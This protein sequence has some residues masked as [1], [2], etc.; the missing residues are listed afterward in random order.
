[1]EPDQA[2][3]RTSFST[4]ELPG[5]DTRD[6][7]EATRSTDGRFHLL[8]SE[9]ARIGWPRAFCSDLYLHDREKLELNPDEP[10]VWVLR[11]NGTHLYRI[12]CDTTG[13]M[14]YC[15]AVLQ[16]WSGEDKLNLIPNPVER[17]RFYLLIEESLR[18]VDWKTA[19]DALQATPT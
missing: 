15:R 5:A 12:N 14:N 7:L 6:K 1:M 9:A 19:R 4:E 2:E 8:L 13:E 18:L 11:E 16:Y 3:H 10:M 17:P